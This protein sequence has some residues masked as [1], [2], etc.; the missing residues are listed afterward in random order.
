MGI[1]TT[2]R[3]AIGDICHPRNLVGGPRCSRYFILL[4]VFTSLRWDTDDTGKLD[5]DS[6]D[7]TR[8]LSF[9]F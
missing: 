9:R 7:K 8:I 2:E 4:L 5:M 1:S 3:V 6:G